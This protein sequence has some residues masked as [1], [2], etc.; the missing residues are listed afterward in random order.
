MSTPPLGQDNLGRLAHLIDDPELGVRT[1]TRGTRQLGDPCTLTVAVNGDEKLTFQEEAGDRAPREL[2]VDIRSHCG[3]VA[4]LLSALQTRPW[5]SPDSPVIMCPD[6]G[7]GDGLCY[8]I[9]TVE[10]SDMLQI[11]RHG[12]DIEPPGEFAGGQTGLDAAAGGG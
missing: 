1:F 2:V 12:L 10:I 7:I 6:A 9:R 8:L 3:E 5:A 11:I 4:M